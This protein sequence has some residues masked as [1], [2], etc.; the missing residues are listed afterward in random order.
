MRDIVRK[1]IQ[2][3]DGK[4]EII[5]YL[6]KINDIRIA[7]F[8]NIKKQ[9]SPLIKYLKNKDLFFLFKKWS[10]CFCVFIFKAFLYSKR[11]FP[12]TYPQDMWVNFIHIFK[13]NKTKKHFTFE[14]F[15]KKM[16]S[17]AVSLK[18]LGQAKKHTK[19]SLKLFQSLFIMLQ[20]SKTMPHT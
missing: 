8:R 15:Y 3:A 1:L 4:H 18:Q 11:C 6:L 7:L 17:R 20:D 19:K 10:I 14:L 12:Q 16:Q 5:T 9:E 13:H 2:K